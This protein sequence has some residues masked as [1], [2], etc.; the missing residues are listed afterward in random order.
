MGVQI[1]WGKIF[2]PTKISVFAIVVV[3][4]TFLGL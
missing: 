4:L 2:R 1:Q 3:L